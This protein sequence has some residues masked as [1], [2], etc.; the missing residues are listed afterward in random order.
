MAGGLVEIFT[1]PYAVLVDAISFL[2]SGLFLLGHPQAGRASY[3]GDSRWQ[4]AKPL[5]RAEGRAALRPRKSE[6][7][8]AGGL[9]CDLQLL[10][11]RR[12]RDL[13]RL[14]GPRARVVR[15]GDRDH[16]LDRR[17][18][19][20]CGG[21][22]PRCGCRT[23]S[24]SARRRSPSG[25]CGARRCSSS[26][27]PLSA[28]PPSPSSLPQRSSGLR[29]RRLQ[30]H[31][32]ELPAGDLPA[33]AAGAHEL[34]HALHRLGH[35]PDRSAHRRRARNDGRAARDDRGRG[36]RRRVGVPLDP[37]LAT[38]SPARDAGAR[39]R[40]DPGRPSSA[41]RS[42]V[43]ADPLPATT[44]DVRGLAERRPLASPGLPA[45]LV[46][47]DDQPVRLAGLAA[48]AAARRDPR[49][50]RERLR[51]RAARHGRVPPVSAVRSAGG[52]LGRP[53]AA[54]ADPRPRRPRT[55][56]RAR[57]DTRRVRLRRIDHLAALRRGVPRRRRHGLLRR[58]VPV[59][60]AVSRRSRSARGRELEA[61]GEPV[62]AQRSPGLGWPEC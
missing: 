48:R 14:R 51:G 10:L 60:P 45:P 39:S 54:K 49:A 6:P 28:T 22:S 34:G 13:P 56:G 15:G 5:D 11:E 53:A 12:V 20:V 46:G 31:P 29:G 3:A 18:R 25:C 58:R 50:R 24:G 30:H 23:D 57:L 43:S 41:R 27:S 32:G 21:A 9:H 52:R 37:L 1:A 26:P 17:G 44:A 40:T 19:L 35:D 59:V 61:R 38:T 8:S 16:L 55:R 7:A 2:G 4:Q 62:R 36:D 47:A 33:P 42:Q